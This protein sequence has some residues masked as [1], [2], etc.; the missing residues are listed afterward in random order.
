MKNKIALTIMAL[1]LALPAVNINAQDAPRGPRG[2]RPD[3]S[4]PPLPPLMA[5]L[6]TN[7][8]GTIDEKEIAA[9]AESLRG[10]DKNN[11]GQLTMDELRP[12]RGPRPGKNGDRP[13]RRPPPEE[14]AAENRGNRPGGRPPGPPLVAAL[15]ANKDGLLDASELANAPAALKALDANSDGRLSGKE[16]HPQGP[17]RGEGRG[18]RG[19]RGAKGPEGPEGSEANG[20]QQ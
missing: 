2:P 19:P 12:E 16:I 6:D 5:A 4:R 17:M 10:L 3:G 1:G 13:D 7:H 15:D 14:A 18:P 11:D 20:G 9:A 8:D